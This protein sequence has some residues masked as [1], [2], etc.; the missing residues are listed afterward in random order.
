MFRY[1]LLLAAWFCLAS[2]AWAGSWA[3]ATFAELSK[4]FGS[5]PRGPTL[6]H[7]FRLTNY[8]ANPV[9]ISGVR[10]SCGCVSA[11]ALDYNLAPGQATAIQIQMDTS[12]FFGM[13]A[14]TVYVTFD[15]PRWEEVRLHVQA[16]AQDN[17]Q[18]TPEAFAL[19]QVKHGGVPSA[20][21]M[22]TV[23]GDGQWQITGVERESNY[24]LAEPKE[25]RRDAAEVSYQVTAAIRADAPVGKW[26]T[27]VWLR[28]NNPAIPRVRVPLTVE[29][30]PVLSASPTAVSVG[31]MKPGTEEERTVTIHG[32][33]PFR[34][35]RIE[36]TDDQLTVRDSSSDSNSVHVLTIRLKPKQA[37]E[38]DRRLKVSTDLREEPPLEFQATAHVMSEPPAHER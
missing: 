38:L 26:Y 2:P 3:D 25:L 9:H 15:R 30:A 31:P 12:R 23:T 24:I 16:N 29:I 33:K 27:E 1:S 14:V 7:S 5:V 10:V 36:G 37:G 20:S 28:T 19:G 13:R 35:T 21:V 4:D 11:S 8:T 22:V 32:S 34:I 17:L 6:T 18:I